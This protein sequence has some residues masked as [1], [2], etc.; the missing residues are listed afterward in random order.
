MTTDQDEEEED[1]G[2]EGYDS[3]DEGLGTEDG[4]G[5]DDSYEDGQYADIKFFFRD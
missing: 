2:G 4:D 3:S 5:Q 1:R